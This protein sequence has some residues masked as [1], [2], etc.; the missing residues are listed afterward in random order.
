MYIGEPL[1]PLSARS[2]PYFWIV[3]SRATIG[4]GNEWAVG[5]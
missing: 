5:S 2:R 4:G 1:L 3:F